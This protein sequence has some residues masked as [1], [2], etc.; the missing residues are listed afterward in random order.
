[1]VRLATQFSVALGLQLLAA[2]LVAQ[3]GLASGS[4]SVQLL[5]TKRGSVGITLPAGTTATLPG[6]L[7][8]GANDFAPLPVVTS[9]NLDPSRTGAVRL[10]AFFET[11]TRALAAELGAIPASSVLGRVPTGGPKSFAPFT[12]SPVS[13]AQGPLGAAG[14]TL[15]LFAQPIAG[16]NAVGSRTDE[17]QMRIDLSGLPDLPPGTYTGTLNLVATTQ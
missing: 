13:T 6:D 7:V 14:G 4:Q 10:V 5:A 12:G 2:P 17:L 1:M 9:W 15:V 16:G 8:T 11:P 3:I